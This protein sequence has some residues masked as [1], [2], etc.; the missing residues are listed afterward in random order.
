MNLSSGV[1]SNSRISSFLIFLIP[2]LARQSHQPMLPLYHPYSLS[3]P[4]PGH[5]CMIAILSQ[6]R[7]GCHIDLPISNL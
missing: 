7:L 5:Q 6:A 1:I 3:L 2:N 4:V